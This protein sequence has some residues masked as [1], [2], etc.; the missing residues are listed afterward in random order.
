[1][2]VLGVTRVHG[3]KVWLPKEVR[4]RLKVGEND[5]VYFYV[6]ENGE[7]VVKKSE[8]EFKLR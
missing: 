2:E 1:M 5:L 8:R 7:V 6:N 3:N 4:A